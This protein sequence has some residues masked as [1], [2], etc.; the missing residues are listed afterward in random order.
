MS[1]EILFDVEFYDEVIEELRPIFADHWKEV[2]LYQDKIPLSPDSDKY[3]EMEKSGNLHIVTARDGEKLIGYFVSFI[4]YHPHYKETLF[5]NNDILYLHPEYRGAD[6]ALGMFIYAEEC[7]ADLGVEV[8]MLHM[9]T[10]K[11]FD[12]LC[13]A[14]EYEN[15]ERLYSKY[16]KKEEK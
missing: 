9:K 12:A 13:E 10:A 5:A 15:V 1:K 4:S 2:A 16:I 7:L 6:T 11:P 3:R 14:L 8:L